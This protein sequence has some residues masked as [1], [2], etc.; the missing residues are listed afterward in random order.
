MGIIRSRLFVLVPAIGL[1]IVSLAETAV[2]AGRSEPWQMWFQPAASP[3]MERIIEFHNFIFIIEVSIVVLVLV[4]MGYIIIRFNAKSN[5]VPSKTTHNTILEVAWTAV[6]L[7]LVIII[8]VPSLKLLYYA[9]RIE[10]G[11]MTLKVIGNQ[12]YWS[13]EYPDHGAF[14]FDS[15]IIEDENLEP[16]QPRLLSVDNSVVLPAETNIRLLFTSADVIH[17]WAVPSLG[18]KLDAV[19]GRVNE[20]WVRINSEGDYYG[21]CSELC[22]VNHGFMPVHIKAVSK[23]DFAAWVEQAKQEFAG[24][25]SNAGVRVAK[26]DTRVR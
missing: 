19:P 8:A 2:A 25:N 17:N 14:A 4:L 10:E 5:P 18:L 9:D 15:I 20:S 1:A 11:E 21:M 22:G 7:L 23:A 6:P 13:Y 16:G 3:V 26:A 24:E 12:W